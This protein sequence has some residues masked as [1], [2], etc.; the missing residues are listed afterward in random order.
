MAINKKKYSFRKYKFWYNYLFNKEKSRLQKIFPSAKIE[1]IG[2]TS[3]PR[4]GGKGIIDIMLGLDKKT[5]EGARS[6]L[7]KKDYLEMENT[8][9]ESRIGLKKDYGWGPFKRRV[10]IHLTFINSIHWKET[11]NF[12]KRLLQN[13]DLCSQYEKIKKEAVRMAKGNGDIYRKYKSKFIKKYS[14]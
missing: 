11:L 12:K 3:V 1:H 14:K 4:L 5:W 8:S 6:T 13:K 10:H 2:S 9:D 7:L